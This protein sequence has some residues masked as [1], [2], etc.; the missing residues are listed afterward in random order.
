MVDFPGGP[1]Q[2]PPAL[3]RPVFAV[4]LGA[5]AGAGGLASAVAGAVGVD[6][7]GSADPWAQS[8]LAISVETGLAPAVDVLEIDVA[9][10]PGAPTVAV[11]DAGT[12]SL[13]YEDSGPMLV[14]TGTVAAVRRTLTGATR[15]AMVNGGAAL[16]SLRVNQSYDRQ[17][18]GDVVRDLAGRVGVAT[19]AVEAGVDLAFHV[20]DDRRSVWAHIAALARR[21]GY[22]A[23]VGADGAL[24]FAPAAGG[25]PVQTVAYATDVLALDLIDATPTLGAVTVVGDGAAG[26]QGQDAASWLVKNPTAV[27]A[28]AG[29][30][31][32]G[33][34]VVDASARSGAAA[35]MVADGVSGAAA[36]DTVAGWL[37]VAGAP[38]VT[39]GS[40]I[41]ITD[42]PQA[43][44][45]GRGLARAVR[46]SYGKRAGFTTRVA[47]SLS[48]PGGAGGP[49][50][51]V[52]GAVGGLL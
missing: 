34:L 19:G 27:T 33:R 30:G 18:A 24:T 44:M 3:R 15:I 42:T 2:A 20:V 45:S 46:H 28:T 29:S 9:A 25:E 36:L 10:T 6:L 12:V 32:P 39:A 40:V 22:V 14:F 8:L 17:S 41:E 43:V 48:A 16:A 13:G 47:L 26:S 23:F 50:G 1:E 37:V 31:A 49:L 35:Q 4:S 51:A 7:G 38:A 11:G 52:A 5:P 21:S